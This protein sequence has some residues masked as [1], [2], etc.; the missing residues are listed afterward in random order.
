MRIGRVKASVSGIIR[1]PASVVWDVLVDWGGFPIRAQFPN[2]EKIALTGGE[3]GS[4][5]TRVIT[6]GGGVTVAEQLIDQDP[7]ARRLYCRTINDG[8]AWSNYLATL[9]VDEVDPQQCR[10]W[11]DGQCDVAEL[12]RVEEIKSFIEA[13]WEGGIIAGVRRCL[14]ADAPLESM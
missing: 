8:S 14:A 7:V 5:L 1:A 9:Y 2:V 11:I 3:P 12:T 13:S 6:F 10:V 4:P